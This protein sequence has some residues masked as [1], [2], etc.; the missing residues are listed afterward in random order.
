M[1]E[2]PPN[3]VMAL[4]QIVSICRLANRTNSKKTEIQCDA[5]DE[6]DTEVKRTCRSDER[7]SNKS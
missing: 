4:K 1:I 2:F 7:T 3:S 5:H 6:K